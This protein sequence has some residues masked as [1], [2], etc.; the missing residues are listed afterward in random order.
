MSLQE[1][2]ELTERRLRYLQSRRVSVAA[3]GD[4]AQVMALDEQIMTTQDTIAALAREL[5]RVA[6]GQ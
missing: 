1:L 6:A 3:Q 4:V 2:L 5:A